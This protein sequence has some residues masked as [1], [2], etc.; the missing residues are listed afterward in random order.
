MP[1]RISAQLAHSFDDAARLDELAGIAGGTVV[2][3]G[4]NY[5]TAFEIALKIRELCGLL[6]EAWSSADLMHGP[7]A[8]IARGWPVLAVAPSGPALGSMKLRSPVWSSE[9][10]RSSSSPTATTCSLP[11]RPR[12]GSCRTSRSG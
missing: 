5:G 4:I 12:C 1:D 9:A 7:V 6:F 10:R 2:A 11:A 8:A 3:R